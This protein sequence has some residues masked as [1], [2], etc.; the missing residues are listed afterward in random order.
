MYVVTETNYVIKIRLVSND[1]LYRIKQVVDNNVNGRN[2]P[3]R[4]RDIF[5]RRGPL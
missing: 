5:E 2:K 4:D 1:L 3:I